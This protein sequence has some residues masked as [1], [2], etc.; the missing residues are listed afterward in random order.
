ML[1]VNPR[2][3]RTVPFASKATGINLVD[4]A[5]RLAA[6]A[7]L[8]ELALPPE[9]TACAGHHVK[10][11]VLPFVR[12][13]G[14]RP[15]ARPGDALDRRGDG[16]RRRLRDRVREGR[17][18][19]RP[20][21][22]RAAAAR[23]SASATPTRSRSSRSR[24]RSPRSA[25]SSSRPPAPRA[26]LERGGDRGRAASRRA[27]RSSSSCAA[28]AS[29]SSST[30][31][32]AG[33]PAATATRSARRRSSPA[34]RA[35]RRSRWRAR[36]RRGDRERAGRGAALAAGAAGGCRSS[37]GAPCRVVSG[38]RSSASRRSGR[39]RSSASSAGSL[40][41]G[42]AGPVLHARG[43]RPGAAAARSRSAS[44]RAASSASSSTRSA[45][46]HAAIAG[47]EPGDAIAV[48]GPLGNG[49]RLDVRAAAAR[50]RRDRDR[51]VPVPRRG[52]RAA[53]RRSS[54]SGAP[55]HAEAAALVPNAE[56][57]IDPVLVTDAMPLDRDVLACGPE[58]MLEAVRA[59]APDAQLAWEAPMACGYGACY[60]CVV[61]I[62]GALEAALRRRA[63][64]VLL[65]NASGCLDALTAP[66]V[67]QHAR[68]VR[69]E[70]GDAGAA[71]GQPAGA[72]RRD[73]A[74]DAELDRAREPGPRALSRRDA[75]RA[76][77]ARTCRSGSRS[78]A[79]RPPS[80]P[81]PAP[82]S[83]T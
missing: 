16:E 67:A 5:C 31:R 58:P 79:S 56:V 33:T 19:R 32:R 61:E 39:T 37:G 20:R 76:A 28:A 59:L 57:V 29:T 15:G 71:R 21:A 73:R 81:R 18:R 46:G 53:R 83:T 55:H 22:A 17:A 51:A 54:A 72:D 52:A 78:A 65:L 9:G 30:R 69:D 63:G 36:P 24:G 45:P 13:A 27:R 4:A 60:G 40:E 6:G 62:D 70:D 2:A 8:A 64:A 77:R 80:T 12:F 47:L 34:C 3:S 38:W 10:A 74:R 25:S 68:R 49:F 26:A 66:E 43:A 44:R 75:A 23:S 82:R 41:P 7:S 14:R 50:R 42:H 11:A 48:F 1:E 35:S